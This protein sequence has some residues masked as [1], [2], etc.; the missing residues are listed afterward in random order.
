MCRD[1][2][3]EGPGKDERRKCVLEKRLVYLVVTVVDAV[4][5]SIFG[6]DPEVRLFQCR[7]NLIGLVTSCYC[8]RNEQTKPVG[9][10]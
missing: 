10:L 3:S 5:S 6:D 9:G 1:R 4:F 7:R 8:G 2:P